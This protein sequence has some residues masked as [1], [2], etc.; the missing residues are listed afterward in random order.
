MAHLNIRGKFTLFADDTTI[1]WHSN[2]SQTLME[3]VSSDI[4]RVKEWFDSNLLTL[5]VDK[6][7]IVGF[8]CNMSGLSIGDCLLLDM[9]SAKFL[10]LE[11]DKD[12]KFGPHIVSLSKKIASGCF[13]IKS[14]VRELGKAIAKN[15]YFALIESR[16]RYGIAFWGMCS[17][18]L[19]NVLF[20]LQKRALRFLLKLGYRESCKAFFISEKILTLTSLFILESVSLIFKNRGRFMN[21]E[22]RYITRGNLDIPL[23]IPTLTLTKKSIIYES[24]KIFNHL[25]ESVREINSLRLFRKRVKGLLVGKAYYTLTEYYCDNL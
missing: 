25:P 13:A 10:G 3:I 16:L 20:V 24:K 8:K 9:S 18:G 14:V 1:Q 12:L 17:Q 11:I 5:N 4:V 23:P 7:N 6:T 2:S 22:P 15:V 19:L 21:Q